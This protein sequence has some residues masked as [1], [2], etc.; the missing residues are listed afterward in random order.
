MQI[1]HAIQR[2]FLTVHRTLEYSG[3]HSWFYVIFVECIWTIAV[4]LMAYNYG[5]DPPPPV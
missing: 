1:F 5:F 4:F 3:G 2:Q